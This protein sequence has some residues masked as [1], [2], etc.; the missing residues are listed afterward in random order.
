MN[1][2]IGG[3]GSSIQLI[4]PEFLISTNDTTTCRLQTKTPQIKR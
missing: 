1:E 3:T 4:S 2:T